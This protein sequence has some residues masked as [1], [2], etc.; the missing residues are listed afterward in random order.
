MQTAGRGDQVGGGGDDQSGGAAAAAAP[1]EA[2]RGGQD[3]GGTLV[4][5]EVW[6][7]PVA[8]FSLA[9]CSSRHLHTHITT[10]TGGRGDGGDCEGRGEAGPEAWR[11]G[12]GG[13]GSG[14][15][16][17]R[18]VESRDGAAKWCMFCWHTK[19]KTSKGKRDEICC[20]GHDDA[21]LV[22][23]LLY[24]GRQGRKCTMC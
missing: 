20:V 15:R 7:L 3:D 14:R 13:R 4:G 16:G 12:R 22:A 24:S 9:S 1:S 10:T 11:G 21:C 2:T 6:F 23:C 8:A 18:T 19:A 5:F 17:R